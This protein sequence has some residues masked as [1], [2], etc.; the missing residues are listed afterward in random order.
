M[1]QNEVK[2]AGKRLP[3]PLFVIRL[4]RTLSHP[5]QRC[6]NRKTPNASPPRHCRSQFCKPVRFPSSLAAQAAA[7]TPQQAQRRRSTAHGSVSLRRCPCFLPARH[8]PNPI[9]THQLV[10][11]ENLPTAPPSQRRSL[12]GANPPSIA[13]GSGAGP[14]AV[15]ASPPCLRRRCHC[16]LPTQ[17]T[18]NKSRPIE[19]CGKRF[20]NTLAKVPPQPFLLTLQT[21]SHGSAS[22]P[23][24][25]AALPF[26]CSWL[27]FTSLLPLLFCSA[28]AYTT[29]SHD[30]VI[31][32]V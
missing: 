8:Q 3:S 19:R 21:K 5:T 14:A 2:A 30:L 24:A 7:A 10:P 22:T 15:A 12:F 17:S 32:P 27:R 13:P 16:F 28:S 26:H 11:P 1:S 25:G 6:G 9:A 20:P 29:V 23:A 4:W 31:P 18:R